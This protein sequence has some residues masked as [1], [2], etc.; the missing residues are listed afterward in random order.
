MPY[1]GGDSDVVTRIRMAMDVLAS[2]SRKEGEAACW[3]KI[4]LEIC[5]EVEQLIEDCKSAGVTT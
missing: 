2:R 4:S 5:N 1:Q 3:E